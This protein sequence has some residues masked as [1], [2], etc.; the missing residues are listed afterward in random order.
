MNY[1]D[2]SF[3]IDDNQIRFKN[4]TLFPFLIIF[5]SIITTSLIFSKGNILIAISSTIGLILGFL[6][7]RLFIGMYLKNTIDISDISYVKA[8]IWNNSIDKDRNFW[9]AGRYKYHFP[10]GLNKRT[11][12]QVIFIHLKEK[13]SAVGFV[14]E[15]FDNAISVLKDKGIEIK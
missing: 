3:E 12:P 4:R 11:N 13:E 8:Q 2:K 10:T 1:K 14:P 9:G 6:F 7:L 5:V 15:N